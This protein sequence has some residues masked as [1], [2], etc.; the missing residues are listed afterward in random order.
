MNCVPVSIAVFGEKKHLYGF[1]GADGSAPM[2]LLVDVQDG[3]LSELRE[4]H[5][6]EDVIE[7]VVY[8]TKNIPGEW[9]IQTGEELIKEYQDG[10]RKRLHR[11]SRAV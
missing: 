8:V 9:K 10:A 5:T 4:F 7:R 3:R 2:L 11:R 1:F 6:N